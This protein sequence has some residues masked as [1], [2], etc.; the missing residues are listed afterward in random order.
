[1]GWLSLL[2]ARQI[3]MNMPAG[4]IA[5]L[6]AG[7]ILFSIGALIYALKRPNFY[8]GVFGFHE[9]WHIF[10]ILGCLAHFILIAIYA[11]PAP[12]TG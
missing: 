4:A 6:L 11:A 1:M 8:P 5:W 10:V 12:Y 9:L 2:A 3:W 7:G